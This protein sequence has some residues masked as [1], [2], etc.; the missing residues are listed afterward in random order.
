MYWPRSVKRMTAWLSR[1]TSTKQR[2]CT[3]S[4]RSGRVFDRAYMFRSENGF[5]SPEIYEVRAAE[6]FRG[7]N[8]TSFRLDGRVLHASTHVSRKGMGARGDP[9]P[10]D[11]VLCA[12]RVSQ[13]FDRTGG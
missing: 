6:R 4:T 10:H 12:P 3:L 13:G 2:E 5:D 9:R 8:R 1:P 11:V 7:V